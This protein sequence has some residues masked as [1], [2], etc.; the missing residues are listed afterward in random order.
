[1]TGNEEE[2]KMKKLVNFRSQLEKRIA[3]TKRELENLQ[4]LMETLDTI[5]L[6]KGFK[7]LEPSKIE[8]ST[9]KSAEEAKPQA[10]AEYKVEIPMKTV[11]GEKLATMYVGEDFIRIIMESDKRFR[12][13]LRSG[14]F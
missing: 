4:N 3:E 14:S 7:R 8:V 12:T 13:S 5:L 2:E 11:T 1:M 9:V 10:L 6:E